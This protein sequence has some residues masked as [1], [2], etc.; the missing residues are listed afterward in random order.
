MKQAEKHLVILDALAEVIAEKDQEISLQRWK[1][2]DLEKK[3]K[4]AEEA[5]KEKTDETC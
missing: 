2:A 1:I 4:D 3:L 5:G